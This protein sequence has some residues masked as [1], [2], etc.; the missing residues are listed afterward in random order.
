MKDPRPPLELSQQDTSDGAVTIFY[1][2]IWLILEKITSEWRFKKIVTWQ[3]FASCREDPCGCL[4]IF[5]APPNV[6]QINFESSLNSGKNMKFLA[7][8][9]PPKFVEDLSFT[10]RYTC[11][12]SFT[13]WRGTQLR[14]DGHALFTS[15]R[16]SVSII[17]VFMGVL[18]AYVKIN[19][20]GGVRAGRG[21]TIPAS[22][23]RL[24]ISVTWIGLKREIT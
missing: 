10:P 22:C 18:P 1:F 24:F 12:R 17:T 4:G 5:F 7:L 8:V 13:G 6:W 9:S 15:T 14:S 16:E 21:S 23:L 2:F 11:N 19:S 20:A 3:F